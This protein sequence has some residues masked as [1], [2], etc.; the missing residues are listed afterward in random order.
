MNNIRLQNFLIDDVR[1]LIAAIRG[2]D[3]LSACQTPNS[4]FETL[5]DFANYW[6]I[7]INKVTTD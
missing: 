2:N 1:A 5:G 3:E 7:H 6:E 4:T